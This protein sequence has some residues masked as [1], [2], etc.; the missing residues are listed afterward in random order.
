VWPQRIILLTA[1]I[2]TPRSMTMCLCT[3]SGSDMAATTKSSVGA[4]EAR[5]GAGGVRRAAVHG[6]VGREG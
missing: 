1:N 6:R 2:I 3:H 5:A 4:G